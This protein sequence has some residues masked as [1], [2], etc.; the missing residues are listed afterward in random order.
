MWAAF[1]IGSKRRY[2]RIFSANL[3]AAGKLTREDFLR[4]IESLEKHERRLGS[5]FN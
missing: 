4:A 3:T 1:D 5:E 2:E